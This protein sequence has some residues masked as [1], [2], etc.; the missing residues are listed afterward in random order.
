[1]T[2][3]I[4][5]KDPETGSLAGAAATGSLCVGGWVLRGDLRAGLS[6][7]QGASPSTFWGED[8]LRAMAAGDPAEAAVATVAGAD[9][10]RDDRQLAALDLWGR[11]AH[12]TGANNTDCKGALVFE[13][14]VVA[15]NLLSDVSVLEAVRDGYLAATGALGTRLIS[16]LTAGQT[17]GGDSRGL[18]S[19]A[20][21]ILHS[22]AAPM[23]LRIDWHAEDPLPAL[24]D[25]YARATSG[26]YAYWARQVPSLSDPQRGLD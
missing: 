21:L 14:G 18:Q 7:S 11:A 20:L 24:A 3:S 2:Y 15:G 19:A 23:S 4:L 22:A 25:L 6:A 26:E 8:V 17:A 9:G 10:H 12:F 5:V 13:N 16:A 1:M